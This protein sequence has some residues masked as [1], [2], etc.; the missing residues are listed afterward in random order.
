MNG[1]KGRIKRSEAGEE[2]KEEG[3]R[4]WKK[5]KRKRGVPRA[6]IMGP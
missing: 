6:S 4:R 5:K 1:E 2:G 3:R